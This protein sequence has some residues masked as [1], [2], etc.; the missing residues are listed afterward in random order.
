MLRKQRK[1]GAN[2][3][4]IDQVI[5]WLTDYGETELKAQLEKQTDLETFFAKA[6]KINP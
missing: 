6:P 1:K 5:C 4:E 2:Q 3:A